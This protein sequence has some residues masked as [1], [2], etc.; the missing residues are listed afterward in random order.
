MPNQEDYQQRALKVQNAELERFS[1]ISFTPY[2]KSDTLDAVMNQIMPSAMKGQISLDQLVKRLNRAP[3]A[4]LSPSPC[5]TRMSPR[6][7][8]RSTTSWPPAR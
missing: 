7:G 3:T 1:V 4:P 5:P 2:V 8:R 6:P